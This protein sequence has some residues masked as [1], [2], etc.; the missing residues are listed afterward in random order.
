MYKILIDIVEETYK[1]VCQE[2]TH[3]YKKLENKDF[4]KIAE[5]II[6]YDDFW[7]MID[8]FILDELK[9]YEK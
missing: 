6:G 9:K 3:K 2:G 4:S 8:G 5:D 1:N 7:N